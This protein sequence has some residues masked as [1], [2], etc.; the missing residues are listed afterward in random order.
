MLR[1]FL[2]QK[3]QNAI[4]IILSQFIDKIRTPDW[5]P[6]DW[7]DRLVPHEVPV[8]LNLLSDLTVCKH[9]RYRLNI[10]ENFI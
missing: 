8:R 6:E 9:S 3:S 10:H 4:K 2:S 1:F 5:I 7:I